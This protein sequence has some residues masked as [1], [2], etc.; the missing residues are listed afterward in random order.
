MYRRVEI[1]MNNF[2]FKV[3]GCFIFLFLV[4]SLFATDFAYAIYQKVAPG[5]TVTLGEFVFEDDFSPST[6]D[7]TIGITDPLNIVAVASTTLMNERSDGWH[8]YDYTTLSTAA[9][10]S[11]RAIMSCG[12]AG[13]GD[14]VK[15]DKSFIVDSSL[16]ST[17]TIEEAVSSINTNT[18]A[19]VLT[20]STS[21]ATSIPASVWNATNRS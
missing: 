10:G 13:A 8:Y 18:D 6:T 2:S 14:L 20:A 19:Q 11:W 12:S 21:L 9:S 3:F 1:F 16:V 5:D 17:S 15:V 4:F 7:C